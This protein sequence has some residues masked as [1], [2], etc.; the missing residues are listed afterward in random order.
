MLG[1]G[2]GISKGKKEIH[3]EILGKF[4]CAGPCQDNGAQ[5]GISTDFARFLPTTPHSF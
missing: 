5:G 4:T 1:E 3:I 2:F